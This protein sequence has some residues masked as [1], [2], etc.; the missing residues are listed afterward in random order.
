MSNYDDEGK[1]GFTDLRGDGDGWYTRAVHQRVDES[2]EELTEMVYLPHNHESRDDVVVDMMAYLQDVY[3]PTE[4]KEDGWEKLSGI[5]IDYLREAWGCVNWRELADCYV[6]E[7]YEQIELDYD[8][9]TFKFVAFWLEG[10][11]DVE[12]DLDIIASKLHEGSWDSL[13]DESG[14]YKEGIVI[15]DLNVYILFDECEHDYPWEISGKFH[16]ADKNIV[17]RKFVSFKPTDEE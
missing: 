17:Q 4:D 16:T 9:M 12:E 11:E 7:E 8:D 6:P 5:E 14:S 10:F 13:Y 1:S 15:Y 2:Q 3:G